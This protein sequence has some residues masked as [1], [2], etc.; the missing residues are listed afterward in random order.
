MPHR[1]T[2]CGTCISNGSEELLE[3]CP[4]CDNR[5]WELVKEN[6]DNKNK[7]KNN[8]KED[9]SQYEA[10]TK[11]IDK[12]IL[13]DSSS[14]DKS[15]TNN[16]T[17]NLDSI[18]DVNKIQKELNNQYSGIDVIK[19]GTY[20]INLTALYRGGRKIIEVDEDGTYKISIENE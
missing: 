20:K 19:S 18:T 14:K 1:C 15:Y 11:T 8:V 17:D 13:T 10:R 16:K 5:S 4:D 2:Q 6:S 12:N 9:E 3:G 7:R